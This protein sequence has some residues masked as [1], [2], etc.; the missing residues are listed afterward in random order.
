M[1]KRPGDPGYAAGWCIHYRSPSHHKDCEAGISFDAMTG[2]KF[3][4]RP[5]FLTDK[6]ESKLGA[7]V[8]A[9]LRRP[10]PEEIA[11]HEIWIEE[12][13]NRTGVAMAAI[14]PFRKTHRGRRH[15]IDCPVCG[16]GKLH[17]SIASNGHCHAA[18]TTKDCVSWME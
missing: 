12:R 16:A 6:G 2:T 18:C 7:A 11:A 14:H 10:T 8:C 17:F 15:E 5:C 4:V 13:M 9:H 1:S 3:D